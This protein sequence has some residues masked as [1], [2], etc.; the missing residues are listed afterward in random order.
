MNEVVIL[1]DEQG[2]PTF[3]ADRDTKKFLGVCVA[4]N[5]NDEIKYF[6]RSDK[7]FGLSNSKPLKNDKIK[8]SRA[9]EIAKIVAEFDVF[10]NIASIDLDDQKFQNIISLYEKFGNIIREKERQVRNRSKSQIIYS[11]ILFPEI[12]RIISEYVKHK[13][14]AATFSVFI[15]DWAFPKN[16][17]S[18]SLELPSEIITEKMN[19]IYFPNIK[20]NC[21]H[22]EL[23]NKDSKRKRFI[24]VIV[25]VI[26]RK[27]KEPTNEKFL[28]NIID[29]ISSG[30]NVNLIH[31][32]FTQVIID[33]ITE[34]MD[35]ISRNR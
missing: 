4:Y 9:I 8:S 12:F 29:I 28:D 17:L 34:S 26:S 10:I 25:S 35:D 27:Y 31:N 2:T 22:F 21:K 23:L 5:L 32:D 33:H 18:I 30:E 7:L 15:D 14:S 1:F 24:D 6:E 11:Q 13:K 16:D 19:E 20:V 3:R